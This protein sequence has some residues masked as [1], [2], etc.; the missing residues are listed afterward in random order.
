[1]PTGGGKSICYQIPALCLDG[2]T[3]VIS[4]LISLM[5]DQIDTLKN[6]NYPAEMINST[7]T[8]NEQ[9]RIMEAAVRNELK[10]LYL[11]PERLKNENFLKWLRMQKIS[12]FAVDEAHCISE[13]GHDFRPDYRRIESV[14]KEIGNPAIL[15]L[16]ATATKEVR[17]DIV[18]VLGMNNPDIIINGF[19]RENLIYGV[20]DYYSK[21][22]KNKGLLAFLGKV[23][24]P[25]IIYVSSIKDAQS[26]YN[27]LS[28]NSDLNYGLYHGKIPPKQ[29]DKTQD[30]FL[31]NRIDVLI[32]TNAFGMGVD[33]SDIR[34]VVHY[35]IPGTI[36]AYYQETGR[37]GRDGK[38]SFCLLQ[39]FSRDEEIQKFFI[40]SKNPSPEM[41]NSVFSYLKKHCRNNIFYENEDIPAESLKI[42]SHEKDAVLKI[43]TEMKA[44][45]IDYIA[46]DNY[47]IDIIKNETKD[48]TLYYTLS[49]LV[50]FGGTRKKID[51]NI[52]YLAKRLDL[53]KY[54]LVND[55]KKLAAEKAVKFS[56]TQS[57]RTV[58]V[59]TEDLPAKELTEYS[60]KLKNKIKYDYAKL[61]AV[62]KYVRLGSYQCRRKYVLNY[63]G[64]EFNERNC[65]K[66]D[67]CRKTNKSANNEI[68]KDEKILL[69]AVYM[70]NGRLGK[71]KMCKLLSGSFELEERFREID[72]FGSLAGVGESK[73]S[74]MITK[75]MNQGLIYSDDGK[76]PTLKVTKPAEN[77]LKTR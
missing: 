18:K 57:G 31:Y 23:N 14:I 43:L 5:K 40:Q 11:T 65:A 21:E 28:T 77:L 74:D 70:N 44:V 16:T 32:A 75:L 56:V 53:T 26:L 54:D 22:D 34:F 12:L 19:N 20:E 72:E 61:D 33:K 8:V 55:L 39:Y 48:K 29:R 51:I 71:L 38:T 36:E 35:S 60:Q 52:E 58:K 47:E 25:G 45:Q 64:E 2:M 46:D 27:Y 15:A 66:C 41:I 67:L 13:W 6:I 49:E 17:D 63:F 9:R 76:Y 68:T 50:K 7:V 24:K 1:M 37:A 62:V 73:I 30:D 59:L 10:L 4:P 3:I 69:F 42:S